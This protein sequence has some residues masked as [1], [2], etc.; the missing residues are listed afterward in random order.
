MFSAE[1]VFAEV[2]PII[3]SALD[4]HNVCV[5][6]HGQTGTGKTFTMVSKKLNA[7]S[8]LLISNM[9]ENS[10]NDELKCMYRMAQMRSQESFLELSERSL[11]K[12]YWIAHLL[13]RFR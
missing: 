12:P 5:F 2:E 11:V 13:Y 8:M 10:V 7:A 9:E 1:D 4:G 3:R 6:A